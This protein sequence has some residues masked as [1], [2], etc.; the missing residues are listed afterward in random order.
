MKIF[1]TD[2]DNTLIYSYKKD[3][4]KDKVL[5]ETKA[6]KERSYMSKISYDLLKKLNFIPIT[7]RSLEQYQR[8]KFFENYEPEYALVANGGI[9][10]H[11]GKIVRE[12]Y[13]K[14]LEISKKSAEELEKG[15]G[16][17]TEDENVYFEV[18][19]VDELFIVTKAFNIEM[20]IKK[21]KN[22]LNQNFVDVYNHGEKLYIFPKE[23]NKGTSLE[24]LKKILE[25][26]EV[27]CA[28]DSEIDISM[29]EKADISI[30]PE[31][32][33]FV[34]SRQKEQYAISEK[35]IFSDK[36]LQIVKNFQE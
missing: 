34:S 4:G 36:M 23:L 32:L 1:T 16:L 20:V 27:I 35:D 18:R 6:G 9:L 26:D 8:I 10:L 3:I 31:R 2:L 12:W 28:G 22:N 21:L 19:K 11:R 25:V 14:S 30:F 13:Q 15:M 17:L 24:R 29:L 5:V 7:T 33:K